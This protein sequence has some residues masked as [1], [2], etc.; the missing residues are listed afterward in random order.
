M[1]N[2]AVHRR[3]T[4]IRHYKR[5][6]LSAILHQRR[7]QV[8]NF[9]G[10]DIR[11]RS[12]NKNDLARIDLVEHALIAFSIRKCLALDLAQLEVARSCNPLA[13]ILIAH[14]AEE[15][16]LLHQANPLSLRIR[17]V[18]SSCRLTS[19]PTG[20]SWGLRSRLI[21]AWRDVS[22]ACA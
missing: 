9:Q 14:R 2:R 6:A 22:C 21:P 17:L 16:S 12:A 4:E 15:Q 18:L 3:V 7:C 11:H 10:V 13:Q 19:R 1:P 20:Y 8:E 5:N